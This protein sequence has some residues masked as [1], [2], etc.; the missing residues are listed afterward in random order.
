MQW[1]DYQIENEERA[2]NA[3]ELVKRAEIESAKKLLEEIGY[4]VK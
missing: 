3:S 1:I 4:S 2:K